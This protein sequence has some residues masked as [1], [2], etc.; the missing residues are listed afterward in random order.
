MGAMACLTAG[1]PTGPGEAERSISSGNALHKAWW[2]H[3]SR[4]RWH[5]QTFTQRGW[6]SHGSVISPDW[7]GSDEDDGA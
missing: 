4:C 5:R 7:Q 1:S 6:S 3:L 2:Q